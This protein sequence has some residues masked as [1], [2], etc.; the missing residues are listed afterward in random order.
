MILNVSVVRV[1]EQ[2]STL[3]T[4]EYISTCTLRTSTHKGRLCVGGGLFRFY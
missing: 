1:Q 3:N 2:Y 4:V